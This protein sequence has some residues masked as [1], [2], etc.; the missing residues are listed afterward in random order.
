MR[1]APV[2]LALALA[3]G[4]AL[5]QDDDAAAR[6]AELKARLEAVREEQRRI[7]A[8]RA[9]ARGES[10]DLVAKLRDDEL[11]I[12]RVAAEI[13]TLD[14]RIAAQG[15]EVARLDA[16]AAAIE[17]R[18]ATQRAQ[19][20]ALLRSAYA[21]GRHERLRILF[22]PEDIGRI[23]RALAYHRYLQQDRV[24]RIGVLRADLDALAAVREAAQA[25]ARALADDR[26]ERAAQA[27]AL[28]EARTTRAA[29]LAALES[30]IADATQRLAA[31]GKDE[32][33]LLDLIARL[34]DA[35][36]D[37]PKVLAGAEPF[38]SLR[39]R[40][41]W[42][43]TGR[44][45]ER[46]GAATGGGHPSEGVLIEARRGT[47]VRA[48]SHGRI[49]FADWMAGYGLLLIV[50]HGDG[51]MSLYAH[52]EAVRAEVGDWVSAGEVIAEAGNSGGRSDS[53]LYFELRAK[54]RPVDP[55][56]WLAKR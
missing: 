15:G 2:L 16:E 29:T 50:D 13:A 14:E 9:G 30:R 3:A 20:A 47:P 42:P 38:A 24:A 36:A 25:A 27:A 1:L 33:G 48:V 53:G 7:D 40:L 17:A 41:P 6:E 52:N 31:L 19:I 5:A 34:R 21:A 4:A 18:L 54:G 55:V 46:F 28:E 45:L 39:G 43:A 8:E 37:I 23:E 56:G 10:Q 22:A 12:A 51:Y 32:R 49:A 26:A 35:I 11:A 44:V